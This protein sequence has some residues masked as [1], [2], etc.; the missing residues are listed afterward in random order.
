[1]IRMK[2][3]TGTTNIIEF[4]KIARL[5]IQQMDRRRPLTRGFS[6]SGGCRSVVW[7]LHSPRREQTCPVANYSLPTAQRSLAADGHCHLTTTSS[8][9]RGRETNGHTH[10]DT[11]STHTRWLAGPACTSGTCGCLPVSG[12]VVRTGFR[13]RLIGN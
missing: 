6:F 8:G 2:K 9:W 13:S 10:C 7:Q 4:N 11:E 5:F 12:A 3:Q 1:M